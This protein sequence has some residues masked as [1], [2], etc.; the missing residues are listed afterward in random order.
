MLRATAAQKGRADPSTGATSPGP[1]SVASVARPVG[2]M[3]R[4]YRPRALRSSVLISP[5]GRFTFEISPD[6]DS[7]AEPRGFLVFLLGSPLRS[8]VLATPSC[9]ATFV[10]LR[11]DSLADFRGSAEEVSDTLMETVID[12]FWSSELLC[13]IIMGR[14]P[15]DT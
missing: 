13:Q 3:A 2:Q 12:L 4:E 6:I 11:G 1:D 14:C 7:S 10:L 9:L 15:S 8:L 5:R